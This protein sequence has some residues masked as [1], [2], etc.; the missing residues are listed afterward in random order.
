VTPL[1]LGI[2]TLGGVFT[3]LIDRNT[4]IPTK[5]SQVFSTAEDNQGAVTINVFQGE[6]EMAAD[7]KSLGRFDLTG[8]PPAPRGVPQIE[9][10]FDIDANGIVNVQ[11]RD[12]ATNKEQAIRIQANGGL[13]D[14]DIDKMVKEAEANKADDEKRKAQVDARN[15]ADS[16]IHS[17][18]KALAEHGDKVSAEDKSAIETALADVKGSLESDDAE[19]LAAKTQTLIQAS[20]KLGEAMY[21]AQQAGADG[22]EQP[23]DGAAKAEQPEEDVVD[24][25]FEEVDGDEKPA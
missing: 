7:N 17:T 15:Q 2:E 11:A 16:V 13:S 5:K 3:R 10:T 1:S 12:K 25:E 21:K 4:T 20:M 6:R 19:A 9:V 23:A 18:E 8:I 14:A 22:A 24:A